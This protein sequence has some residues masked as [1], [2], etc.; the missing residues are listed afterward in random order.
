[1]QLNFLN[2]LIWL[3]NRDFILGRPDL[4]KAALEKRTEVIRDLRLW[5]AHA[6]GVPP[7]PG[8]PCRLRLALPVQVCVNSLY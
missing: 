7:D 5:T 8:L 3:L 1:M 6:Y 2:Q 4:N